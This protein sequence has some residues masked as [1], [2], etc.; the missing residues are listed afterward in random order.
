MQDVCQMNTS[1]AMISSH[2]PTV[3]WTYWTLPGIPRV[4]CSLPDEYSDFLLFC[5][6]RPLSLLEGTSFLFIHQLH[7][8]LNS[9]SHF[10]QLYSGYSMSNSLIQRE[11]YNPRRWRYNNKYIET[12]YV[13]NTRRKG[14]SSGFPLGEIGV[15]QRGRYSQLAFIYFKE[16]RYSILGIGYHKSLLTKKRLTSLLLF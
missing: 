9:L 8:A 14:N 3:P 12:S 13:N 7:K 10:Y 11:N 16:I 2:E 5:S 15:D 6:E 4:S 1:R